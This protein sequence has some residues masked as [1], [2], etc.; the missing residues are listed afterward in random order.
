MTSDAT[1][2]T[3]RARKEAFD[4]RMSAAAQE[5]P[6]LDAVITAAYLPIPLGVLNYLVDCEL[7]ATTLDVGLSESS[8]V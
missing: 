2:E 8:G 1:P 4:A 7:A 3:L 6:D 5:I